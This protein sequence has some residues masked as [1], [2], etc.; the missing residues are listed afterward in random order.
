MDV[1]TYGDGMM[2]CAVIYQTILAL[3]DPSPLFHSF[4]AL[5]AVVWKV[6][7]PQIIVVEEPQDHAWPED[8]HTAKMLVKVDS[9][10]LV[11]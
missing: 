2:S 3:W 6:A 11:L 5:E 7:T 1:T 4:L 8:F 10:V 9:S